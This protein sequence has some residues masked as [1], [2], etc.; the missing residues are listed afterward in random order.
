M[1][2]VAAP[3]FALGG[4]LGGFEDLG[5]ALVQALQVLVFNGV[6]AHGL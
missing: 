6:V 3:F 4:L 1:G 2:H 5:G